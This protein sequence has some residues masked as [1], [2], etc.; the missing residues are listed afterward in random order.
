MKRYHGLSHDNGSFLLKFVIVRECVT[1]GLTIGKLP[2]CFLRFG[3]KSNSRLKLHIIFGT[4]DERILR[5]KKFSFIHFT[6]ELAVRIFL[7]FP[8]SFAP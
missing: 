3:F 7:S 5:H 6:K 8:T 1:L 2:F 4:L